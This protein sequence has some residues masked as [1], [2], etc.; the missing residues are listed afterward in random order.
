MRCLFYGAA[1]L[2]AGASVD[3]E[4]TAVWVVALLFGGIEV[5]C[6]ESLRRE[7]TFRCKEH[8]SKRQSQTNPHAPAQKQKR[9]RLHGAFFA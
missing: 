2:D 6:D 1:L 9:R 5:L 8:P 4:G 7:R 3:C